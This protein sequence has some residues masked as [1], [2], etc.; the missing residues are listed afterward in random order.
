MNRIKMYK[1]TSKKGNPMYTNLYSQATSIGRLFQGSD[2]NEK[3]YFLTIDVDP[4]EL[5][6]EIY[7]DL[8]TGQWEDASAGATATVAQEQA[9]PA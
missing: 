7:M 8:T 9:I 5:P 6:Q 3:P 4:T 2:G 1:T